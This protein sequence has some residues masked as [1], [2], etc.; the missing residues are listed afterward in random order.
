ME[1]LSQSVYIGKYKLY[2]HLYLLLILHANT[3]RSSPCSLSSSSWM[4]LLS[5]ETS[6][7][8]LDLCDPSRWVTLLF[9]SLF[10][11]MWK[12]NGEK[13]KWENVINEEKFKGTLCNFLTSSSTME[14]RMFFWISLLFF[15]WKNIQITWYTILI[16]VSHYSTDLW[17]Q[18]FTQC[19]LVIK[20]ECKQKL[21]LR[22]NPNCPELSVTSHDLHQKTGF[23]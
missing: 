11:Q 16:I 19:I 18:G 21:C 17:P 2:I 4:R 1:L 22:E 9:R 5:L 20:T 15:L 23:L 13:I 14:Q 10:W 8:W 3:Y 12:S 6:E 7:S